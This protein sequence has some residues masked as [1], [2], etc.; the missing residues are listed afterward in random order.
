MHDDEPIDALPADAIARMAGRPLD[1]VE[2]LLTT[3]TAAQPYRIDAAGRRWFDP[4]GAGIALGFSVGAWAGR[5]ADEAIRRAA[6]G[7]R[8]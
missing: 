5:Q 6:Q 7:G 2:A 4:D 3:G 1:E 8:P